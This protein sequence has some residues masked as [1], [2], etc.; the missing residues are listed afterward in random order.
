MT[1]CPLKSITDASGGSFFFPVVKIS[2]MRPPEMM[3]VLFGLG[4]PPFPSIIVAFVKAFLS[5]AVVWD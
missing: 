3:M 2:A 4:R 5:F 1:Y